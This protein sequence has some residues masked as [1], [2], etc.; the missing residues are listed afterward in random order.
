M[1]KQSYGVLATGIGVEIKC[2]SQTKRHYEFG[3]EYNRLKIFFKHIKTYF[4]DHSKDKKV[5]EYMCKC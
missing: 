4:L 2:L 3:K 5:L 1:S